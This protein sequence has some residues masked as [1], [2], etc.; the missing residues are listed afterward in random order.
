M[1]ATMKRAARRTLTLLLAAAAASSFARADEQADAL[2]RELIA[3][4]VS[5]SSTSSSS[6]TAR[7]SHASPTSGTATPE[8]TV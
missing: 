5:F 7:P 1:I 8:T 4:L 2:G 6:G 3:A